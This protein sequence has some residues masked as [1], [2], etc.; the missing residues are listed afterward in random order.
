[1]A[2]SVDVAEKLCQSIEI[3]YTTPTSEYLKQ[4]MNSIF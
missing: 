3:W 4:E 1:M 2:K